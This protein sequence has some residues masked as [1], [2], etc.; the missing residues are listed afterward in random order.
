MDG[1]P[2]PDLDWIAAGKAQREDAVALRREIHADPEL[3]LHCPRTLG[4]IKVAL[5]GLPL[6]LHEGPSTSGLVATLRGR[7]GAGR[8]VLLRGDMD[9]LEIL[10]DTGLAFA[11]QIAGRMHACGHDAH[12]AMLVGA[13]KALCARRDALTGTVVFMFQPGEEGAHGARRMMDD[14]LLDAPRPDAAFALHV[15]PNLARGTVSGRSGS[16]LA[17][18]DILHAI[19]RGR[20]GHAAMPHEAL[21]PVPVLCEIVT[22]LQ[23]FVTRQIAALDP[24]VITIGRIAA[25]DTH[26][27][28]PAAAELLGTLRTLSAATRAKGREGFKRMVEN[29]AA[30]H[31]LLGEA[32]IEPGYPPTINDARALDLMRSLTLELWGEQGWLT[33]PTPRM[34]SEDFAYVLE[35]IPGAMVFLGVAAPDADPRANPPLHNARMMVDE[36]ALAYGITLLCAAAERFLDRGFGC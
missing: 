7:A 33:M 27:V 9:A 29:V 36:A 19:I 1:S 4:K 23:T 32:W 30:A 12:T 22:A 25:G 15:S 5:R 35:E 10:E 13:A 18:S 34:G 31:G 11:S 26:N 17:S 16:L 8:T 3:G 24:A 28:I 14:G 20:G 6:E 21:D 2:T